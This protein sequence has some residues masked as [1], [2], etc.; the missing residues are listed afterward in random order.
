MGREKGF[1]LLE[2]MIVV[3]VVSIIMVIALPIYNDYK[4]RAKV[5][6]ALNVSSAAMVAVAETALS[7]TWPASNPEAGLTGATSIVGSH[8]GGVA[9]TRPDPGA[10]SIITILMV[11]ENRYLNGRTIVLDPISD[12]GSFYWKCSEDSTVEDRHLPLVCK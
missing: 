4:I 8:V 9:V 12:G 5:S 11:D 7:G 1:T 3:A 10:P 2:L 6:E